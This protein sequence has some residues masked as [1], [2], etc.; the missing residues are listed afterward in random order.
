MSEELFIV[1][2]N[3]IKNILNFATENSYSDFYRKKYQDLNIEEIKTYAD[4]IKIPFLAKDELLA[5]PLERRTFVASEKIVRYSF[6]SGTTNYGYPLIVPHIYNEHLD[7]KGIT[8]FLKVDNIGRGLL[9]FPTVQRLFSYPIADLPEGFVYIPGDTSNL[10]VTAYISKAI[11]IQLINTTPTTLY[12]FIKYLKEAGFKKENIKW[13]SLSGEYCTLQQ[14]NLFKT[15]FGKARINTFYGMT[16]TGQQMGNRCRNLR[17]CFPPSFYHPRI[18]GH[19]FEVINEGGETLD[20]G[21][22][23]EIVITSLEPKAFPLLRYRTGDVGCIKEQKCEC[24]QNFVLELGGRASYDVLRFHGVTLY[25]EL[26]DKS[27]GEVTNFL[28]PLFQMHVYE[29]IEGDKIMPRLVL[30]LKL[31]EGQKETDF[32]RNVVLDI[33]TENLFLS[34]DKTLEYFVKE[35]IFMP[36]EIE[37]VENWPNEAKA[38]NIISHLE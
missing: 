30:K 23:G 37:F 2:S 3:K 31:K 38:K 18:D 10:S 1:N 25:A 17:R 35:K 22:V 7:K 11:G 24:G 21:E 14:M 29:E 13:I 8:E 26:I 36:L 20:E 27:L 32:V 12:Q 4:F 5:T 15:E 33:V 28:E 6:T 9:L 16:E 19:F 34:K